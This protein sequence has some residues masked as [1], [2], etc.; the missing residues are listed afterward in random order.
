MKNLKLVH[1]VL[2]S[3]VIILL[4]VVLFLNYNFV[5]SAE[6]NAHNA[7]IQTMR[8][9]ILLAE[10]SRE[11][12]AE[13][14]NKKIFIDKK[15]ATADQVLRMIP[16][17]SAMTI[18]RLRA[19]EMSLT[20]RLPK[21]SPR[22]PANQPNN[23]DLEIFKLFKKENKKEHTYYD[24]DKQQLHYY[25]PIFLSEDCLICHGDPKT[26]QKHWG[27]NQGL[28]ITGGVMENWKSGEQ[29]GAFHLIKDM[30]PVIKTIHSQQQKS[31][32]IAFITLLVGLGLLYLL[33]N[34]G[35]N[36]PLSTLIA[37]VGELSTGNFQ[38]EC[39]MEARSDEIGKLSP[40]GQR[41]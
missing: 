19:E 29:H 14:W 18:I 34:Y 13:D 8:G 31:Y 1:K 20:F 17:V 32:N 2:I 39:Q 15:N 22:N 5:K 11:K 37:Y 30:S 7:E 26:S 10:S 21:V 16:V 4:A 33:L 24:K 38:A 27:N 6:I 9:L 41:P 25:R 12:T 28:D 40:I 36:K 35:L 3:F 23:M